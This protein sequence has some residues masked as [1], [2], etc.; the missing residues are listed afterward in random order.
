MDVL[1]IHQWDSSPQRDV[2]VYLLAGPTAIQGGPDIE[3]DLDALQRAGLLLFR[4]PQPLELEGYMQL[5]EAARSVWLGEVTPVGQQCA[6][7]LAHSYELLR[8]LAIYSH[9]TR[10]GAP[11]EGAPISEVVAELDQREGAQG[12]IDDVIAWLSDR[13]PLKIQELPRRHGLDVSV[14]PPKVAHA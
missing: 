1:E 10:T 14:H 12:G 6:L 2:L 4:T 3:G 7:L 13:D 8:V 9:T 5:C 11:W